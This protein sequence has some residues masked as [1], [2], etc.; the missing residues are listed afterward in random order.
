ME[1]IFAIGVLLAGLVG[2]AAV[3]PIATNNALETL[4]QTRASELS[5]NQA[6][7]AKMVVESFG[8]NTRPITV[9]N[10]QRFF[11][12]S[13]DSSVYEEFTATPPGSNIPTTFC[14]D[15][16][17]LTSANPLRPSG[18]GANAD[19]SL[20]NAYD[21]SLFP[22]YDDRYQVTNSPAIGMDNSPMTDGT[23]PVYAWSLSEAQQL[24]PDFSSARRVPRIG[25]GD[26]TPPIT[27][28]PLLSELMTKDRDTVSVIKPPLDTTLGAGLFVKERNSLD[29][30][31]VINSGRYSYLITS[32]RG[33][34][35]GSLRVLTFLDRSVVVDPPGGYSARHQ[36]QP[37]AAASAT[38]NNIP[39]AEQTFSEERL[40]YVTYA[41]D[42]IRSGRGTFRYVLPDTV[43]PTISIGDWVGLLRRNYR[44]G[45]TPESLAMEWY[46]IRSIVSEP[47][48]NNTVWTT[49]IE[50]TGP[51]WLFHPIQR[52]GSGSGPYLIGGTNPPPVGLN[53]FI[54]DSSVV[55]V[56][57]TAGTD[58][59]GHTY[60]DGDPLYGT[61]IILMKNV[62]RVDRF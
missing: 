44:P 23:V 17:F 38:V 12:I 41:V 25:F 56:G 11:D 16:W 52:Y 14:F 4:N 42:L 35:A 31:S 43:D 13:V 60:T 34:A 28:N 9:K 46:Q 47:S 53:G 57:A 1:V 3:L 21:R 26:I 30:S 6:A 27:L 19:D 18:S 36:L 33:G 39:I 7:L 20:V 61:E 2:L 15:P 62:I 58:N 22:C 48:T 45:P 24:T 50:V 5:K 40:G 49:E 59:A 51:D 8:Q 10:E 55:G 54:Y 29:R 37:Y 32:T